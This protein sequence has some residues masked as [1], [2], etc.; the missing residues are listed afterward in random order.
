MKFLSSEAGNAYWRTDHTTRR[1]TFAEFK[2][3][4]LAR[5]LELS[6]DCARG[7]ERILFDTLFSERSF[8][9][10]QRGAMPDCLFV[11]ALQDALRRSISKRYEQ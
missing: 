4:T 7:L 11:G 2:V 6:L 10:Q 8:L 1:L 3:I 9:G 5:L